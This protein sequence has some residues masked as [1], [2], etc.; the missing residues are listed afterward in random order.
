MQVKREAASAA[1]AALWAEIRPDGNKV[2]E[3]WIQY[4]TQ[5][6]QAQEAADAAAYAQFGLEYEPSRLTQSLRGCFEYARNRG[7]VEILKAATK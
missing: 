3:T 6:I 1:G 2:T 7:L 5:V 4:A